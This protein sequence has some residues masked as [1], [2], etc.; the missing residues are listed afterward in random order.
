MSKEDIVNYQFD[1]RTAE[2]QQNIAIKGGKRSGEVRRERKLLRENLTALLE[3]GDT[4]NNMCLEL[5]AKALNGDI[6]AFE[7]IRDT[8][9]EKPKEQIEQKQDIKIS[10]DSNLDSWGK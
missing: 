2:E 8:I 10:M 3:T 9:G 7:V 1:K 4:Q 6:R 5:I